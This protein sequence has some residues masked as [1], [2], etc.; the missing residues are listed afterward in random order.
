MDKTISC[1]ICN[2]E[3]QLTDREFELLFCTF[4]VTIL[5]CDKCKQAV[6]KMRETI[7]HEDKG[8]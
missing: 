5:V 1:I 4:S 6:I 8:E 3:I 2:E 7:E